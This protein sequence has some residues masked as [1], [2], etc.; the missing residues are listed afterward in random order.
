M[1]RNVGGKESL[2]YYDH[3]TKL[4]PSGELPRDFRNSNVYWKGRWI[5]EN[6]KIIKLRVGRINSRG[7]AK[8]LLRKLYQRLYGIMNAKIEE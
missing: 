6:I 1:E 2:K 4:I 5:K 3:T 8:N 7:S